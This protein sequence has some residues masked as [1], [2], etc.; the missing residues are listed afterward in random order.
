[1]RCYLVDEY[2]LVGVIGQTVTLN[3]IPVSVR[4]AVSYRDGIPTA[5]SV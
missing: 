4:R 3:A 1:V 5:R 2:I